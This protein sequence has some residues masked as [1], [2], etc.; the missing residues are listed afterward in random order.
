MISRSLG[1]L[2]DQFLLFAVPL[3]VLQAT[4]SAR[5]AAVAFV[6]EWVPRVIGFPLIGAVI[7]GLRLKRV[8]VGLD[9]ARVILLVLAVATIDVLGTFS[10]LT[11]L[12]ACMSVCYV[13]NFLG[14]E[15]TIPNNLPEEDFP[16]AHSLV[17][18]VEQASQVAGPALAALIYNV[19]DIKYV[20]SV[21]AILFAISSVNILLL[22]LK[23]SSAVNSASFSRVLSTNRVALRILMTRRE[24]VYLSGLT[25]VVN[26]VY[27]TALAISAAVTVQHFARGSSSFGAMQSAA[28]L[29]ALC[30]FAVIPF[31]V[32]RA[33]IPFVGKLSLAVMIGSG[34]ALGFS[35]DFFVYAGA[36]CLLMAFDGGFNVYVRTMRST[37]LPKEHLGKIMGI[38]GAVNLLSIPVS[39]TLVSVLAGQIPLLSIILVSATISVTLCIS[40]LLY[41]KYGLGYS[42]WFPRV[43]SAGNDPESSLD[44]VAVSDA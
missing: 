23:D 41:G 7:D 4:H 20:L 43:R 26:F 5:Y 29:A 9:A 30:V 37:V 24:I 18:G 1:S 36:Y 25:W 32:R 2:C 6:I 16:R 12:M 22:S 8:F 33:G 19:G 42:S 14:I 11:V 13:V 10:T 34:F 28:A 39:G 38:L 44:T 17:Q 31:L 3:A 40:V 35:P 27:G 15:A 21:C